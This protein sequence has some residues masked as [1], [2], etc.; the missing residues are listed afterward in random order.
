MNRG[1]RHALPLAQ[2]PARLR[3]AARWL[4]LVLLTGV[5]AF[6]MAAAQK[7]LSIAKDDL[8]DPQSPAVGVLQEPGEALGALGAQVPDAVG[9]Q[10]RWVQALDR[11]LI[12]PRTN[13]L[14]ET[15]VNLRTTE[16]LLV[17]TAH[18]GMV[19][20]PHRPHTAWLDCSNCHGNG[21]FEE[22]AGATKIGM[23]RVL[24]G[25]KCGLCHGAVA[26]PLTE[27]N[28]CHSVERGSPEHAAFNGSL[29]REGGGK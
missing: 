3:G 23:F 8:H 28:R 13:I 19:K 16:V 17:N 22:K 1:S 5:C 27:C 18:L 25:E 9:N 11:G 24:A 29:V 14:P 2:A 10:V 15:K 26:F 20:F 6:A 21:L 7:W 4:L 12:Q